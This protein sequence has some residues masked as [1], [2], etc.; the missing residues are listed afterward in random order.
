MIVNGV[1]ETQND[2]DTNDNVEDSKE[3]SFVGLWRKVAITNC[4]E[5]DHRKID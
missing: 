5:C 1:D 3:F 2:A 4:S